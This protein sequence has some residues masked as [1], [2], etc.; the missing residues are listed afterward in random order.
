[1]IF[2]VDPRVRP[3]IIKSLD[4]KV[5]PNQYTGVRIQHIP[6][7]GTTGEIDSNKLEEIFENL[8]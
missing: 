4:P 8:L 1:M 7:Y 6:Q 3:E 2:S 5:D